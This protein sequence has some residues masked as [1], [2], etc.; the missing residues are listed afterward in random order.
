MV[1]QTPCSGLPQTENKHPA[2]A[3]S[4]PFA[5]TPCSGLPQSGVFDCW[6][7]ISPSGVSRRLSGGGVFSIRRMCRVALLGAR[8]WPSLDSVTF[9]C[10]P[11]FG[12]LLLAWRPRVSDGLSA[13]YF[14]LNCSAKRSIS[15]QP[16]LTPAQARGE[17]FAARSVSVSVS[18][19]FSSRAFPRGTTFKWSFLVFV[20]FRLLFFCF[21]SS[22]SSSGARLLLLLLLPARY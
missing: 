4:K 11:S 9:L 21:S 10:A 2:Q 15:S 7:G 19:S 6:L 20:F 13:S 16:K 14:T 22:S 3:Y 18:L 1:R 5:Q 12:L 8:N 17:G